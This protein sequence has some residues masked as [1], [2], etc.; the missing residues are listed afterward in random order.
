MLEP[1]THPQYH[2]YGNHY[3][4]QQTRPPSIIDTLRHHLNLVCNGKSVPGIDVCWFGGGKYLLFMVSEVAVPGLQQEVADI[5]TKFSRYI[6][7]HKSYYAPQEQVEMSELKWLRL[8]ELHSAPM[9]VFARKVMGD[10]VVKHW[11]RSVSGGGSAAAP[12]QYAAS[13]NPTKGH[14]TNFFPSMGPPLPPSTVGMNGQHGMHPVTTM[15]PVTPPAAFINQSGHHGHATPSFSS[16]PVISFNSTPVTSFSS[17]PT[18]K[19]ISFDRGY[20]EE[21]KYSGGGGSGFG[22]GNGNFGLVESGGD[23]KLSGIL[24]PPLVKVDSH[25][26]SLDFSKYEEDDD[27]NYS[28]PTGLQSVNLCSLHL[29]D[30]F[31]SHAKALPD[32]E[33]R[34]YTHAGLLLYRYNIKKKCIE[35]MLGHS[36]KNGDI[37]LLVGVRIHVGN[38]CH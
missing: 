37:S 7:S 24:H 21:E 22:Y 10:P 5:D 31:I 4:H 35:G 28:D 11:I 33:E 18:T 13:H 20:S 8:S 3:H 32:N 1:R 29:S 26:T 2:Q 36:I 30:S 25:N 19:V 34:M 9:T 17:N 16:T 38:R 23:N 14:D 27:P 15:D 12:A 6:N